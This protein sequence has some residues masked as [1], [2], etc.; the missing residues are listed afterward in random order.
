[1]GDGAK[2]RLDGFERVPVSWNFEA[3]G[4]DRGEP[5]GGAGEVGGGCA[6]EFGEERFLASVA[7]EFE[8]QRGLAGPFG[9]DRR[10]GGEERVVDARLARGGHALEQGARLGFVERDH[11]RARGG[12]GVFACGVIDGKRLGTLLRE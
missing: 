9:E 3:D 1:M 12:F 6:G 5:A 2:L 10:E 4:E 11:D 8:E 7:F